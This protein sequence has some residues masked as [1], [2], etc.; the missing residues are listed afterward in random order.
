MTTAPPLELTAGKVTQTV[1]AILEPL[2]PAES[3]LHGKA[4]TAIQSGAHQTVER[5]A[6]TNLS[7]YYCK[8]LGSL[9]GCT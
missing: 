6:S 3:E 4:L 1:Q 9:G 7:D 5:L 8:A 2:E